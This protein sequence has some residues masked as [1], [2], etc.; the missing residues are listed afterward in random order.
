[1]VVLY[2]WL[3]YVYRMHRLV[4]ALAYGQVGTVFLSPGLGDANLP[5]GAGDIAAWDATE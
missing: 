5:P 3:V 4:C 2:L 1:M